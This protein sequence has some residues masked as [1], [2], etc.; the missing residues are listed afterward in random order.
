MIK[1]PKPLVFIFNALYLFIAVLFLADLFDIIA[2]KEDIIKSIFHGA[3]VFLSIVFFFLNIYLKTPKIQRVLVCLTCIATLSIF[4][5]CIYRRGVLPYLFSLGSWKT[6]T[7]VYQNLES[8]GR[9]VEFQMKNIGAR[10]YE[11]RHVEV[12]YLTSWLLLTKEVDPNKEFGQLWK[13]VDRDVNELGIV[14]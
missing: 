2:I 7:I 5:Y 14:W 13:K 9:K 6:Q 10:G 3:G 4:S 12:R 1:L 8:R 11:T